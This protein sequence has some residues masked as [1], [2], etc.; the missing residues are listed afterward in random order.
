[1]HYGDYGKKRKKN[2]GKKKTLAQISR[3][4]IA[5]K[6]MFTVLIRVMDG[7]D[8]CLII[9]KRRIMK[10]LSTVQPTNI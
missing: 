2:C 6:S 10:Q 8:L 1:M 3:Q 9:E 5:I 4:K 7:F